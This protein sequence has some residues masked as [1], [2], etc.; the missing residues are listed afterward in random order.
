ML[1]E[2]RSR[3]FL[4]FVIP[5]LLFIAAG[6][7]STSMTRSWRYPETGPLEFDRVMAVVLVQDPL[8]RRLGE[9]ALV[10]QIVAAEAVALHRSVPDEDLGDEA[11]VREQIAA[12]GVDGVVVMRLVYDENEVTYNAGTYPG[13]YYSFWGYYGWAYPIAYQ[14]GYLQTDRLVGIETNVYDVETE[15]L[16]WSGLSR[17]KNPDD[18]DKLVADTAKAV[19]SEMKKYGFLR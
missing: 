16:V 8:L 10:R 14:P 1:E 17:T 18:V 4:Y 7:S 3:S 19:R 15:K 12:S 2:S 11:K 6:C 13:P 5:V 9:N